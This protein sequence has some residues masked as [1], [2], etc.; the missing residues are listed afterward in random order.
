MSVSSLTQVVNIL[1]HKKK[2]VNILKQHQFQEQLTNIEIW[3]L[4]QLWI[5]SC[6]CHYLRH[7]PSLLQI[8]SLETRNH[9]LQLDQ[10]YC[11][12]RQ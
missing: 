6:A 10:N 8:L 11:L 1:V 4:L 2:V 12:E 9:S 7:T 3:Q 5:L